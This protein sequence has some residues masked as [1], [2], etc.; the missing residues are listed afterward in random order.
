MTNDHGIYE[1][2]VGSDIF[3]GVVGMLECSSIFIT[4]PLSLRRIADDLEF[5]T[6]KANYREFLHNNSRF[7]QPILIHD[8]HIRKKV[9]HT[10]RL[11][12]LKDVVLARALDDSTFNVL[13]SC[14][15]YNQIDII[16]HVQQNPPFLQEIVRLYVSE[17]VLVGPRKDDE[18]TDTESMDTSG[19]SYGSLANGRQSPTSTA[20][21]T[22]DPP[23]PLTESDVAFRREVVIL[24]Q[25]L[26]AMGKNVQLPARMA[27]FR[28]LVD[29]GVLFAVQ[30]T[31]GLDEKEEVSKVVINAA[32]EILSAL[33]DHDL[34]GV[35]GHVHKQAI[36]I[37]RENEAGRIDADRA[38]TL[39]KVLCRVMTQSRDFAVQCQVGDALK[40]LLDISQNPAISGVTPVSTV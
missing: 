25:Q 26:C 1:H 33:L 20:P 34:H 15:L 7:H 14:I 38:E 21:F 22:F 3:F 18:Y 13:N 29:R 40:A 10:Y 23:G 28:T 9:H 12:F 35:R 5:P 17:E 2:I 16:N 36:A 19:K 4:N 32:G 30:W 37:E 24:I 6:H 27:L 8:E 11:Q 31:F 39:L